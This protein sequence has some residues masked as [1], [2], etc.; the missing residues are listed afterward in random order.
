MVAL[1]ER[2]RNRLFTPHV[3]AGTP[4]GPRRTLVLSGDSTALLDHAL[5]ADLVGA[6]LTE[7][8]TVLEQP[9]VWLARPGLP[10]PHPL[11]GPWTGAAIAAFA[12]RAATTGFVVVTRSGCYEPI[13]GLTRRWRRARDR[14]LDRSPVSTAPTDL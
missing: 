12:E 3:C 9:V 2:H 4:G 14:R 5:R 8:L 6:L 7:A 1:R 11:D 10:D 13:T